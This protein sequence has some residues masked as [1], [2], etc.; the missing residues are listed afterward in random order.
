MAFFSLFANRILIKSELM[1]IFIILTYF[2]P[3]AHFLMQ[4]KRVCHES[5]LPLNGLSFFKNTGKIHV[6]GN[7]LASYGKI[8]QIT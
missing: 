6:S 2:H 8:V 3:I 7:Y 5:S 4:L 1:S